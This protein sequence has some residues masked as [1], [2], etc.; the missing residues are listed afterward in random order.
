MPT[1][2]APANIWYPDEN[3]PI[4]PFENL[5]LQLAT[6]TNVA[7]S[8]LSRIIVVTDIAALEA[9]ASAK[10]GDLAFMSAPG[11]GINPVYW[12][13]VA[14]VGAG[15]DWR[16]LSRVV[17]ST[18]ANLDSFTTAVGVGGDIQIGA[19]ASAF[20]SG[21][22]A[23]YVWGGTLWKIIGAF[24]TASGTATTTAIAGSGGSTPVFWGGEEPVT[25]P[26]GRFT[27]PPIVQAT[28]YN[29]GAAILPGVQ[30]S[31]V[32]ITGFKYRLMRIGAVPGAGL[33][34]NW[35]ATQATST[36]AEG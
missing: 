30:V 17:A 32:T 25:F 4:V 7:F 19:G 5:F 33:K 18:K 34:V 27:L 15:L 1:T 11:T 8:T 16:L 28:P 21:T 29:I 3:S 12:Q 13:A 20:V 22:G 36:S 35:S 26:V 9:D 31:D 6:S 23:P 2:G 10:I 24:A 14:D